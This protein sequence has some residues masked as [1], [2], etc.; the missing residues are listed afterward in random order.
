MRS[1]TY[2]RNK[3]TQTNSIILRAKVM[4]FTVVVAI[5]YERSGVLHSII[6]RK[7][8]QLAKS[9]TI[10]EM[11]TLLFK[12]IH[13]RVDRKILSPMAFSWNS[14]TI[15]HNTKSWFTECV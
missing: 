9:P 6:D 15:Q 10:V 7:N 12:L 13:S 11:A 1:Q 4:S 3:Q 5:F 2:S 8:N 14:S